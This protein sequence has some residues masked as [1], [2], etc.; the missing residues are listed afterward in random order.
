MP[1]VLEI[2]SVDMERH[3]LITPDQE[4]TADVETLVNANLR[5]VWKIANGYKNR[6]VPLEELISAGNFGLMRAAQKFD[7]SRGL[8]FSTYAAFWIKQNITREIEKQGVIRYPNNVIRHATALARNNYNRDGLDLSD[9]AYELAQRAFLPDLSLSEPITPGR[10]EAK[11]ETTIVDKNADPFGD[12]VEEKRREFV[13]YCLS[14]LTE[15]E[16]DIMCRYFGLGY[17]QTQT[18]EEIGNVWGLSRERIRQLVQLC[19]RKL[20]F[21]RRE[22]VE[23][24][25][26]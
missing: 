13:E 26:E 9:K 12:M 15:R 4:Q 24:V 17:E 23:W 18:F 8:R 7:A 19:K 22:G 10:Y 5:L 6:G 11:K 1:D 14:K 2:Y 20:Q 25:T 16:A 3:D 21:L